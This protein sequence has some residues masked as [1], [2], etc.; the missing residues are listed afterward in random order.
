MSCTGVTNPITTENLETIR[1]SLFDEHV[2]ADPRNGTRFVPLMCYLA[3]IVTS[4]VHRFHRDS[5]LTAG[6][7]FDLGGHPERK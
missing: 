5:D 1:V 2:I 7:T 6:Q 3:R 4:I